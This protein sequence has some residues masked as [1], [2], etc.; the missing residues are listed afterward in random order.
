MTYRVIVAPSA[1]RHLTTAANY[2]RRDSRSA[3]ERWLKQMRARILR[4]DTNPER[5]LMAP[6]SQIL[7]QPIRELLC[8]SGNR[9][10]YR[11]LFTIVGSVVYVFNIRH[12][13]MLPLAPPEE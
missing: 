5:C 2:L 6:E 1:E 13:S 7:G 8:G 12:G 10:T 4:L 9:G 3:A 11:V